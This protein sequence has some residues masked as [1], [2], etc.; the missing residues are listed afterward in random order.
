MMTDKDYVNAFKESNYRV[1][2]FANIAQDSKV[3]L[4]LKPQPPVDAKTPDDGDMVLMA[5]VEHKVRNIDF[6]CRE[7]FPYDRLIV[8]EVY[9]VNNK[10][11]KVMMYVLENKAGTH[12]AV[13]YGFTQSQWKI[14]DTYDHKRGRTCANFEVDKNL[15]RFC[16][17]EEVF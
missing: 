2:R 15:V 12:A 17:I 1:N 11:D 14:K 16:K 6:T 7:D 3:N 10:E 5:R 4:M 9:K 8:D 13:V